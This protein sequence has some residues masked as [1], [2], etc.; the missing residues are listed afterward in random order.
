ML[1]S[2]E[3]ETGIT[4]KPES[5]YRWVAVALVAGAILLNYLDRVNISVATPTL[6]QELGLSAGQMGV[7]MSAFFWSYTLMMI[8]SGAFLNKY[9]PKW[10][11]W[12]ALFG[13]GGVTML[14]GAVSSFW[15]F[16]AVRIGL[17]IT[18][19]PGFPASARAVSVWMP[20]RERTFAT[21]CYDCAAR[22]G[23]AFAPPLVAAIIL[24]W[25]W[26]MSFVITG[27]LAVL[28]SF[29]WIALYKEPDEHPKV[30]QSELDYIRQDEVIDEAGK[31]VSEPIPMLKLFTYRRVLQ[32]CV[33]YG[34]YLY[35]WT[36]FS[37]WMPTYLVQ[38][39]GLD[40]QT[41]GWY[42]MIPY[43]AAV[44]CELT[45]GVVFDR[46][47]R[48]GA[49]NSAL[50]RTGMGIGLIG[51]AIFIFLCMQATTAPMAIFW[52]S[53]F[54]G[55]FAFGASNVWA[56]PGDI[57]PY[58][59]AGG[60]GGAYNFIG[61]F[62]SLLAPMVTGFFVQSHYGF[63]GAFAVCVILAVIAGLLFIFNSYE[64]LQPK[65]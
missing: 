12:T 63:N 26:R 45:G 20:L 38:D 46:W 32:V 10:A 43:I 41:M 27:G 22:V 15:S 55:I 35:V 11:L 18:E 37:T 3:R 23:S 16:F 5:G 33:A 36:V 40:T 42:A 8:P 13:W 29:V 57:A 59:Q 21:A 44:I 4:T 30:T 1:P 60:V 6:M 39:R 31:V 25:G 47:Y 51:S 28:Y 7:L 65:A 34:L 19:A 62:G 14:T 9:G 49:S 53:C 64:R 56:I 24:A 61:N 48:A 2:T 17:G 54:M 52:I 50:R 58:G